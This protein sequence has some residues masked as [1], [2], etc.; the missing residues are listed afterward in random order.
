MEKRWIIH[1]IHLFFFSCLLFLWFFSGPLRVLWHIQSSC[2]LRQKP[3]LPQIAHSKPLL[4]QPVLFLNHFLWNHF[5]L[6]PEVFLSL[7]SMKV[8]GQGWI[9]YNAILNS[10]SLHRNLVSGKS[11]CMFRK[12]S[13]MCLHS[14]KMSQTILIQFLVDSFYVIS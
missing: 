12:L 4:W 11:Y 1:L 10:R 2:L 3:A 14:S 6:G 8:V 5:D 9:E 7:M 13:A